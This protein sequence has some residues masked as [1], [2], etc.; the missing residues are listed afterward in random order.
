MNA[1]GTRLYHKAVFW[2]KGKLRALQGRSLPLS[3]GRHALAESTADRYGAIQAPASIV[4]DE[5]AVIEMEC[6][7]KFPTKVVVRLPYNGD[8][9]L[10]LVVQL[11]ETEFFVKTMWLN[12]R[13]DNHRTLDRSKYSRA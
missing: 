7:G 3:Y 9:D 5:H 8:C 2:P 12:K 13:D 10:I 11:G 1:P 6:N 4:F